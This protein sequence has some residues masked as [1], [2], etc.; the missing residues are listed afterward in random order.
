MAKNP[1]TAAGVR[2]QGEMD[3]I[4]DEVSRRAHAWVTQMRR[5]DQSP[6][7]LQ[8][9]LTGL[10]FCIL[11]HLPEDTAPESWGAL[12][13]DYMDHQADENEPGHHAE[14]PTVPAAEETV[15]ARGAPS[16]ARG[17]LDQGSADSRDRKA[18]KPSGSSGR[19]GQEKATPRHHS[20]RARKDQP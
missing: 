20:K 3:A 18:G 16:P 1:T 5:G 14:Q 2:L 8:A 17:V 13:A 9:I 10:G 6:S 4:T 12:L 7:R 11:D 19:G 15:K